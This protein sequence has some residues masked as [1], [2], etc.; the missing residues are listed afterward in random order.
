MNGPMQK[1][2]T[3]LC[4]L[5]LIISTASVEAVAKKASAKKPRT[6]DLN[7][8][9][10]EVFDKNLK[11]NRELRITDNTPAPV[12]TS[13]IDEMKLKPEFKYA[14]ENDDYNPKNDQF[15]KQFK[16]KLNLDF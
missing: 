6:I 3:S 11:E 7:L 5:S 13:L 9:Q 2:W 12:K 16:L 15:N 1:L 14:R 10:Q 8:N 4:A